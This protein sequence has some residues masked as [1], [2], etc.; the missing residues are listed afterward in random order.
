[1]VNL[2][3]SAS[4]LVPTFSLKCLYPLLNVSSNNP[5]I[6]SSPYPS[7]PALVVYAGTALDSSASFILFCFP[8][9]TLFNI[10]IASSGVIASVI[11]LKSMH[12]TNSSGDISA[13]ILHT[14]L[15]K[16][17]AHKS[18]IAFTTAPSA[19][20]MTPFSG[21]IQRSWES[22]TRYRH[23]WPQFATREERVRPLMRSATLSIA[24][25]TMSF[26][27]P[28]VNVCFRSRSQ[29]IARLVWGGG[30][31]RGRPFHGRR[32]GN[33]FSGCSTQQSSRLLRSWHLNQSCRGR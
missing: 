10:S 16:D 2:L 7:Q 32:I 20:W 17:L 31:R 27:R 9:S 8:P 25:Q 21:P 13:T 3:L 14:G 22:E 1:M 6:L 15:F 19:R 5:F 30:R 4:T 23:V 18:Q 29:S 33:R 12:L 24:L 11:Y 28:I 26:P